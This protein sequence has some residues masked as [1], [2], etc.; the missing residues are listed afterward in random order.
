MPFIEK[1][2]KEGNEAIVDAGFTWVTAKN[3][4]EEAIQNMMY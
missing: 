1:Q 4:D 3:M 2:K